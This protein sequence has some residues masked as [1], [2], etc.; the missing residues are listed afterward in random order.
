MKVVEHVV[1]CGSS[2]NEGSASS[3][4]GQDGPLTDTTDER[5]RTV[6]SRRDVDLQRIRPDLNRGDVLMDCSLS[7]P[8]RRLTHR[9]PRGLLGRRNHARG[10]MDEGTA[11]RGL[12]DVR[13]DA[14]YQVGR[15]LLRVTQRV[16]NELPSF[17]PHREDGFRRV[18][19]VQHSSAGHWT[20]DCACACCVN[21]DDQTSHY[22]TP[23]ARGMTRTFAHPGHRIRAPGRP[24]I[25][26]PHGQSRTFVP[27]TR[28]I[29][30][31]AP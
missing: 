19:L 27:G 25:R 4:V 14:R 17:G 9:E 20:G 1:V 6:P 5:E 31:S 30:A 2:Q 22:E 24:T 12:L 10:P 7:S 21:T 18:S 11:D 15:D 13:H 26:R 29:R 8:C 23:L 28:G 3:P 16:A